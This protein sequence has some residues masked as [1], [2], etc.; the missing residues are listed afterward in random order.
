MNNNIPPSLN[1][2]PSEWRHRLPLVIAAF[3]GLCIA[4]YLS[5]YQMHIIGNVWDPFFGNGTKKVLTSDFSK[6]FPIP[7]ALLGAIGYLC[8]I[9]FG[10]IGGENRWRTKPWTV[11]V[12]GIVVALLALTSIVLVIAQL[13]IL[14]SAC[15]LCLCSAII[16]ISIVRP[17]MH[18]VFASIHYLKEVKHQHFSVWKAMLGEHG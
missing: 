6:M 4:L 2:N 3:V 17:A 10:S 8:D 1:F 5:F 12:F 7:D 13:I 14:K 15:T 16:S 18:E 9:I 11:L